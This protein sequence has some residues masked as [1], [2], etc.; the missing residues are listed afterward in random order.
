MDSGVVIVGAGPAGI[1]AAATLVAAGVRPTVIDE[2]AQAGG[3]I[4]RRPPSALGRPAKTLYGAD[5][6]RGAMLHATF[7]ALADRINY[8]PE[9][10][11]WN[12]DAQA[13]HVTGPGG[14][15]IIP[16]RRLILATGA[17]DRIIPLPGWTSPGVYALGGAQ[18]ALK[19]QASLIGR[20]VVF[21]GVGPLL[22]LVAHQYAKAGADVR[23]VLAASSFGRLLRAAPA[24]LRGGW[25]AVRGLGFM[26][27]LRARG[28]PLIN[29][30]RP[31]AVLAGDDGAVRAIRY[32]RD[33]CHEAEI[34]CDAV[35]L[36]Y[37]LRSETQLADLLGLAFTFDARQRQWT[38]VQD[39]CGRGTVAGVYLAGD[40]TRVRGADAARIAGE[41]AAR[42]LLADAGDSAQRR[43]I[44]KLGGRLRRMESFRRALD[45]AAFPFP[46][47][48]AAAVPDEVM[49]CRCEG[50]TAGA[51]RQAL[52]ETGEA[53]IN[54]LKAFTRLGMGRCQGRVCATTAAEVIATAAGAPVDA[55]GRLRGQAPIKPVSLRSLAEA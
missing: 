32:G 50:V 33:D 16:W 31:L 15:A 19:A 2:A 35:A 51:L 29:G 24:L 11:V 28:V 3:Q 34:E 48:L 38:P 12:A 4:F 37:G 26:A 17:M 27:S 22:Y 10:Q 49:I 6:R 5:G 36:G 25:P 44:D 43:A 20:R 30:A 1:S 9:T 39:D 55:V 52:R 7:D 8:R 54:R 40:G 53:D 42:V 14:R 41:R 45:E 46:D 23:A 21:V 18:I 13:L 47:H